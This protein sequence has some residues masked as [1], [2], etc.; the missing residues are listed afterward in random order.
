MRSFCLKCKTDKEGSITKV[1]N[2]SNGRTL[3]LSQFIKELEASVLL[4]QLGIRTSLRKI[5]L[6]GEILF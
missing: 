2:P 6:L 3:Y 1:L 4:N 5:P